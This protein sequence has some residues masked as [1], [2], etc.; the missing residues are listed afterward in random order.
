MAAK[1]S[2]SAGFGGATESKTDIE[3]IFILQSS[4]S[5]MFVVRQLGATALPQQ[6]KAASAERNGCHGSLPQWQFNS[7]ASFCHHRA[8]PGDPDLL[9]WMAGSSPAMT[10]G[11]IEL[12]RPC[13]PIRA[14]VYK[15][16]IRRAS[17]ARLGQNR[18]TAS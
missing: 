16:A 3:F 13:F 18:R 4:V 2:I 6:R 17:G 9:R 15:A 11:R 1:P 10:K 8:W 12:P 5:E 14:W 7:C